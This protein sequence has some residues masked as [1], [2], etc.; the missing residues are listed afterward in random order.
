LFILKFNGKYFMELFVFFFDPSLKEMKLIL[1]N[2]GQYRV[3]ETLKI[4]G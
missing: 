3:A 2:Q 4:A 1:E